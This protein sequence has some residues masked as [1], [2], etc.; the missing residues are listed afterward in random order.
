MSLLRADRV[1]NRFN[2]T[3]PI[4]V[5]PSTV[6]GD[7][8]ITGDLIVAGIAVTNSIQIGAA[9]TVRDLIVQQQ[10]NLN[11]LT[12]CHQNTPRLEYLHCLFLCI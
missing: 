7:F 1:A 6:H 2:N 8:T 12:T 9:L 3:G 4:I 10:S 11:N 5:G